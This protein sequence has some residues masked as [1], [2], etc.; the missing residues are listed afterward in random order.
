MKDEIPKGY[1]RVS[2]VLKPFNK[3]EA[4]DPDILA[5]AAY[6]GERVHKY[7][8]NHALGLFLVDV[9]EDCKNYVHEFQKWFDKNVEKVHQIE[10]RCNSSD[11]KLSGKL[12]L[13]AT[14]RGDDF[15]SLIDIKTPATS[16]VSWRLQTAA[17]KLLAATE[18]KIDCQRRLCVLLPKVR[19]GVKIAEYENHENDQRFFLNALELY[20]LFN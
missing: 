15:P 9:D 5:N 13:I 11:I 16:S 18:L 3:F 1:V 8:E 14:I 6:R 2:D 7:C 12:D 17:Y 4:I 10:T 19:E 20:R